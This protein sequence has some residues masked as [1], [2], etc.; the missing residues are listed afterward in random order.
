MPKFKKGRG[1]NIRAIFVVG[2]FLEVEACYGRQ[3]KT[4]PGRGTSL[5]PNLVGPAFSPSKVGPAPRLFTCAEPSILGPLL[6]LVHRVHSQVSQPRDPLG[7]EPHSGGVGPDP[8][9]GGFRNR[10]P[11]SLTLQPPSLAQPFSVCPQADFINQRFA[12]QVSPHRGTT[13]FL[14]CV[15]LWLI[16]VQLICFLTVPGLFN[17][18]F[19]IALLFMIFSKNY[20]HLTG[21]SKKKSYNVL[22][23]ILI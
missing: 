17:S 9:G 4:C 7:V 22:S 10:H 2:N 21:I 6:S 11:D 19:W 5:F 15:S 20:C 14:S 18:S 23:K 8:Y 13:I 3:K 12:S 1:S 16:K